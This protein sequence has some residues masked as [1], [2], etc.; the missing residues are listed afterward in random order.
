MPVFQ[1]KT[2]RLRAGKMETSHY[3]VT[4]S[5]FRAR[6][7]IKISYNSLKGEMNIEGYPDVSKYKYINIFHT[8]IK[9]FINGANINKSSKNIRVK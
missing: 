1:I 5:R 7:S 4:I 3:K 9:N 2:H 6:L 8:F